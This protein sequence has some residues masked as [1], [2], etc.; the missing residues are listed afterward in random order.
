M[1]RSPLLPFGD[2]NSKCC[3]KRRWYEAQLY[4]PIY[5]VFAHEGALG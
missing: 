5:A 2:K 1:D 4:M 3:G